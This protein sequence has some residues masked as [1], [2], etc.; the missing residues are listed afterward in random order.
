L[1]DQD[2]KLVCRECRKPYAIIEDN[3]VCFD[4]VPEIDGYFEKF[5]STINALYKGY[6]REKFLE[7]LQKSTFWEMDAPNKRVGVTKKYWWEKHLGKLRNKTILDL[8]CGVNYLSPY[9]AETNNKVVAIDIC[10][11][12]VTLLRKV[13]EMAEIPKDRYILAVGDAEKIKFGKTF[14]IINMCN[15]L[16][17]LPDREA[18]MSQI[19]GWLKDGGKLV[20]EEANYYWPPRWVVE[21]DIVQPNPV[22]EYFLR[23]GVIEEDERGITYSELKDLLAR[24]GFKIEYNE[25]DIN[26]SG[27]FINYYT[28]KCARLIYAFDKHVLARL[29]PS[30]LTPFE[31]VVASKID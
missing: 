9:W 14:D 15:T 23:K 31:Y 24:H 20:I 6:N 17:H 30:I 27:Y 2:N 13:M 3:I 28:K 18:V 26:Y 16:H 22:H 10:K 11:D 7:D 1:V 29:L 8:G 19:G 4:G 12:E 21:T 25:K 5:M